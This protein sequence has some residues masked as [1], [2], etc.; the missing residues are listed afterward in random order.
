MDFAKF[1]NINVNIKKIDVKINPTVWDKQ[2]A[3]YSGTDTIDGTK[4]N[5]CIVRCGFLGLPFLLVDNQPTFQLYG[6][7]QTITENMD[8]LGLSDEI[9]HRIEK[10]IEYND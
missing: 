4:H 6:S 1:K 2:S 5:I 10:Y 3:L 9:V 7:K 8:C